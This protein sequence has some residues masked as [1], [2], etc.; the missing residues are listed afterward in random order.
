MS[1]TIELHSWQLSKFLLLRIV[2]LAWHWASRHNCVRPAV[3]GDKW[4][5]CFFFS[6]LICRVRRQNQTFVCSH[7]PK[8]PWNVIAMRICEAFKRLRHTWTVFHKISFKV[9]SMTCRDSSNVV[10]MGQEITFH[11]VGE[12]PLVCKHSTTFYNVIPVFFGHSL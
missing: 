8:E 3:H 5:R 6:C 7:D 10:L 9:A 1:V 4:R 11:S 12:V 2:P